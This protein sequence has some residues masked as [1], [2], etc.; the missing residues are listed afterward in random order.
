PR[1]YL[2]Q[3]INAGIA[4]D[5]DFA[6][7]AL[8]FQ[9]GGGT[10]GWSKQQVGFG[11]DGGWIFLLGPRDLRIMGPQASL[12]MGDGHSRGETRERSAERARRIALHTQQVE[13]GPQPR[14]ERGRYHVD[15]VVRVLATK[16]IQGFDR[17]RI[18]T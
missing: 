9:V 3:S 10:C 17:E 18:E 7:Y 14:Q 16:A 11:I 15:M 5:V 13:G 1:F 8:G 4:G 6:G 12:D 2:N